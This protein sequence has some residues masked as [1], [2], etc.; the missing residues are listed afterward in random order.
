LIRSKCIPVQLYGVEACPFFVRDK[1]SFDFSLIRIFMK[2]FRT[3]AAVVVTECQILFSF[4]PL[5]Y[6]VDIRTVSFILRFRTTD[7]FICN[8]FVLLAAGLLAY[9]YIYSLRRLC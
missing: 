5:R 9:I 4:L 7:H 2:P 1:H 3:A 6:Q 8:L